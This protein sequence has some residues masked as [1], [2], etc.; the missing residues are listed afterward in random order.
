MFH[1]KC[2]VGGLE[3]IKDDWIPQK[4]WVVLFSGYFIHITYLQHNENCKTIVD[5]ITLLVDEHKINIT[6][7]NLLWRLGSSIGSSVSQSR[8]K[9]KMQNN[10]RLHNI[11]TRR[12]EINIIMNGK[13]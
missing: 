4:K 11:I 8:T 1:G 9:F 12:K 6:I 10:R 2:G 5:C 13:K 7:M 3:Y